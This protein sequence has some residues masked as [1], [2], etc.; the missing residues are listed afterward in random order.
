MVTQC[1][2]QKGV[3]GHV[4]GYGQTQTDNKSVAINQEGTYGVN[5]RDVGLSGF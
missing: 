3:F 1:S 4:G 2:T 5:T